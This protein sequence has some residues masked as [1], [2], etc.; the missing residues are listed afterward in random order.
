MKGFILLIAVHVIQRHYPWLILWISME[1]SNSGHPSNSGILYSSGCPSNFG[2]P[3]SFDSPFN[4]G[5]PD[6]VGGR[7]RKRSLNKADAVLENFVWL[8]IP[9]ISQH[10]R[11]QYVIVHRVFV[12]RPFCLPPRPGNRNLQ[13][14]QQV[15]LA[16]MIAIRCTVS[17]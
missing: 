13:H 17:T 16:R 7:L 2:N 8:E 6:H 1:T 15:Q 9:L 3:S 5:S 10:C 4:A 12:L 11:A 14:H